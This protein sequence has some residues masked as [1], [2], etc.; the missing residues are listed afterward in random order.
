[1]LSVFH[2]AGSSHLPDRTETVE[3]QP[4]GRRESLAGRRDSGLGAIRRH[5]GAMLI[6]RRSACKRADRHRGAS[7]PEGSCA[8]GTLR[9]GFKAPGDR[10]VSPTA[11]LGCEEKR[12]GPLSRAE[13]PGCPRCSSLSVT[14]ALCWGHSHGILWASTVPKNHLP[15][16]GRG[17]CHSDLWVQ[18]A[19]RAQ[20]VPGGQVTSQCDRYASPVKL[21]NPGTHGG[22]GPDQQAW[23]FGW[24]WCSLAASS[25]VSRMPTAGQALVPGHSGHLSLLPT[26]GRDVSATPKAKGRE[27]Q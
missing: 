18:P 17:P 13:S 11:M 26:P 12:E 24:A 8:H 14:W 15:P 7:K 10:D 23:P 19:V 16:P 9:V 6:T 27:W 2:L 5:S 4:T 3:T 25:R 22:Q 1:M 20:D 21:W